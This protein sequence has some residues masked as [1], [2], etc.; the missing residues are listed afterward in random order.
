MAEIP[1]AAEFRRKSFKPGHSPLKKKIHLL[2]RVCT[3]QLCGTFRVKF[4]MCRIKAHAG[5]GNHPNNMSYVLPL[6]LCQ[7]ELRFSFKISIVW[8][9]F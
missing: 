8:N 9:D 2:F 1:M 5:D 4:R 6:N 7:Y 3:P